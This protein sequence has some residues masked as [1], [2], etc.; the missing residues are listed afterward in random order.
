[1]PDFTYDVEDIELAQQGLKRMGWVRARMPVLRGIKEDFAR[2]KPFD[3][4]RIGICLHVEAKTGV[5]LEAL[6]VGGA[7]IAITG[8][9]GTAQDEIAAALVA[10]YGIQV[11]ARKSETYDQHL[12][13]AAKVLATEPDLLVDNGADL[14]ILTLTNQDF[15]KVKSKI[16]GATEETTTG[17]F[18]LR[19]EIAKHV[20]PTIVINDSRAKR[21][22]ENRYGVGQSVVDGIMRCSNL[23]IGGRRTT[24]IGYGYCGQGIARTLRGL[25]AHVTI[26]DI[27]PLTRLEAH[28]EGYAT[29][30]L[31]QA[32]PASDFVITVTGRPG[33]LKREH[34][35]LLKDGAVL[36][37]AGMFETEIDLPGLR[38]L[39]VESQPIMP[40]IRRFGLENGN[41]IYL[42]SEANSVNLSAGDGNPIEVMD[43]GLAMQSLTLAYLA[44]KGQALPA[45]PQN[46]PMEI[47]NEVAVRTLRAWTSSTPACA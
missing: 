11:F 39:A 42:L 19:E 5:W 3:G 21:I 9:P 23:L 26:V 22:I 2:T 16:I 15:A 37:N 18:R 47:Q 34:L 40:D 7:Q 25:G 29:A 1:M 20:F 24:V 46:V 12:D 8:S 28:T 31:E 6:A 45:G 36:C 14:H 41:A 17:G 44:S 30:E 4:L 38:E 13:Y 43:L 35:A 10:E 32:L 33:A 27:D